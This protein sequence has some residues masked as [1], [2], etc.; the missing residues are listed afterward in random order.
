[1]NLHHGV[2]KDVGLAFLID[3]IVDIKLL[4]KGLQ[5]VLSTT[6]YPDINVSALTPFRSRIKLCQT[7]PFQYTAVKSEPL[8]DG[9][10]FFG[11]VN[12]PG[13]DLSYFAGEPVPVLDDVLRRQL[14][15]R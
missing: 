2:F 10:K 9:S 7:C 13:V 3:D 1:M 15:V 12:M 6:L 8:E 14:A 5:D 4:F 11:L